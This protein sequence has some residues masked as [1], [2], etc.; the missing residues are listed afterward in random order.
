MADYT[1]T[2]WTPWEERLNIAGVTHPGVY[3]LAHFETAPPPD[4]D[5]T[6]AAIL[7]I[8]ETCRSLRK[9]WAN[10]NRAVSEGKPGH[11]GGLTYHAAFCMEHPEA[12]RDRLYVSA[13]PIALL[14]PHASAFIRHIERKLLWDFVQ[15][16]GRYPACNSK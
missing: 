16:H 12:Y 10:F 4:M 13:I 14:E 8:G 11:S 1:I 5:P 2:E 6:D 15:R 3:L 9:R 7:Y